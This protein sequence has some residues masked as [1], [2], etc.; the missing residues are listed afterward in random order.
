MKADKHK[1][2]KKNKKENK[3]EN[4]KKNKKKKN[5]QAHLINLKTQKFESKI[6][7]IQKNEQYVTANL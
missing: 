5:E 1:Q 3:K 2:E 6:L 7:N 4:K